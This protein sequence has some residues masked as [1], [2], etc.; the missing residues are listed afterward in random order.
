MRLHQELENQEDRDHLEGTKDMK[1]PG[2][3]HCKITILTIFKRT[4]WMV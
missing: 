4:I 3:A 1:Y 2:D